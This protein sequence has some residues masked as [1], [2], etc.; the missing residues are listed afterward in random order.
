MFIVKV[1]LCRSKEKEKKEWT[2]F[3]SMVYQKFINVLTQNI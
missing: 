2:F 1:F 3:G